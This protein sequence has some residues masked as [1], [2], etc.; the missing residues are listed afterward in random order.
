MYGDH[1]PECGH[2]SHDENGTAYHNSC[3]EV[4]NDRWLKISTALGF[5]WG[6][7]VGALLA[8]LVSLQASMSLVIVGCLLV[9]CI[10]RFCLKV[11]SGSFAER[12]S[13]FVTQIRL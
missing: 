8:T 7:F 2:T 6:A 9:F 10:V 11:T 12:T 1:C 4:V 5:L 3:L 13:E